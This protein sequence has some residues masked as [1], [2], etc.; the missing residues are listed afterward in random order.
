MDIHALQR[1]GM[2]ISEIPRRANHDRNTIR[3]YL[4]GE[5]TPGKRERA[6]T[7]FV[8]RVRR[9]RHREPGLHRLAPDADPPGPGPLAAAVV[10]RA[11]ARE[12]RN[13]IIEHRPGEE[14]PFE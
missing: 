3:A 10:R 13:A 8:R 5:R 1:Q 9:L 14:T 2:T 12:R 6:F 11:R 4:N 7:R